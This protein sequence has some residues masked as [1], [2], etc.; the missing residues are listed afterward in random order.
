[1]GIKDWKFRPFLSTRAFFSLTYEPPMNGKPQESLAEQAYKEVERRILTAELPPGAWFAEKVIA[2][3]IGLGRTPVREAVQRL[4]RDRLI[5]VVPGKGL[6]VS[7]INVS[8]QLLMIELRREIEALIVR[9]AVK[10]ATESDRKELSELARE[11][12]RVLT[13]KDD[14]EFYK[15]D[16]RFKQLLLQCAKNKFAADA[17]T[18]LW[19][20][21][22]RFAWFHRTVGDTLLVAKLLIR[23]MRA[24]AGGKLGEAM[25]ANAARMK[26]LEGTAKAT[27]RN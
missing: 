8:D 6:R 17:I 12:K 1:M 4:A 18:P 21:S 10:H 13:R 5:E 19:A 27:L 7:D 14:P 16:Y 25:K 2:E 3:K 20:V 24:I 22:R 26:Y 23:L 9:R 11:M 15:L